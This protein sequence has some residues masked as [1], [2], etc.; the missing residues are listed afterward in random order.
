[1]L[2][3]AVRIMRQG[4]LLS[5]FGAAWIAGCHSDGGVPSLRDGVPAIDAGDAHSRVA[6]PVT[7]ATAEQPDTGGVSADGGGVYDADAASA[8]ADGATP[9]VASS[10]ADGASS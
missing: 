7:D 10:D 6:T 4:L 9:N 5:L 3:P 1:M 2:K 8:D